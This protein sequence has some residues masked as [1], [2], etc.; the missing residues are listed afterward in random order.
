MLVACEK[1][2]QNYYRALVNR[3]PAYVGSFFVGVKTTQI[4]CIATCHARKPKRENVEFYTELSDVLAAGFRPCKVCKPTENASEAPAAVRCAIQLVR[5]NPKRKITDYQLRQEGVAPEKVRRW[6]KRHYGMTFHGFQRM[7]RVNSA[8]LE[9]KQGATATQVAMDAGYDSLSGFGYTYKKMLGNSPSHHQEQAVILIHRFTTPL[10]PMFV[11]AT[12]N[13]VCL[14][15]FV[16]RRALETEF[17]DLQKRL[18]ARI[19]A[20][21]NEFTAQAER[22]IGEYFLGQRQTFDLP[23]VSPGTDFQNQVWRA[24]QAIPYGHTAS[25]SEQAERL[26]RP[27]AVRAVATANGCNRIAIVIP[28]HRVIGKNGQLVGYAG[29]LERKKWLLAHERKHRSVGED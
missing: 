17:A 11:C 6:F 23:L 1:T 29:G 5:D 14:L 19:I 15:E 24:L 3:D 2:I 27:S 9:L 25:Y 22:Q 21:E 18:N 13:G 20:G 26:G 4:F 28:C 8:L 7:F 16:E 12:D 10:G